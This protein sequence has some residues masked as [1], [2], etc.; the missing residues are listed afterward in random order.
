MTINFIQIFLYNYIMEGFQQFNKTKPNK[1]IK[2][3]NKDLNRSST[4]E[5]TLIGNNH[6]SRR[7][8]L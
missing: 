8:T 2:T 6:M 5:D 4:K 3:I 7:S 1:P